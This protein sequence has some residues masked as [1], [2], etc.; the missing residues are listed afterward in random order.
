MGAR[1]GC[2]GPQAPPAPNVTSV[3]FCSEWATECA[4]ALPMNRRPSNYH[5][6]TP[7]PSACNARRSHLLLPAACDHLLRLLLL[8]LRLRPRLR[9]R[10]RG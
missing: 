10:L 7:L 2:A 4:T 6:T 9:P 1:V 8:R 5:F 3:A